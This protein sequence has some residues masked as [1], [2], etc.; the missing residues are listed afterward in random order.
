MDF[1]IK[2]QKVRVIPADVKGIAE[3]IVLDGNQE[4]LTVVFDNFEENFFEG[5]SEVEVI[6]PT[7]K[8]IIRF[9]S[10]IAEIDGKSIKLTIPDEIRFI[11]RREYTRVELNIPVDLKEYDC[12]EAIIKSSAMN[13]S[14]G[15]MQVAAPL[16]FDEGV[17]IEAEFNI[18][19]NKPIKTVLEILRVD[20]NDINNE[21]FLSGRFNQISNTDRTAII[22]LCFK[23]QLEQRCKNV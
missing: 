14:G 17:L 8:C 23:K 21:Y 20:E 19:M 3:G 5:G 12:P 9:E 4:S 15:G 22:H 2:E 7:E 13:I 11:Q 18:L 6:I 10:N 1:L 16:S